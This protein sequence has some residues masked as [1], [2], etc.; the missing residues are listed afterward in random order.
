[1]FASAASQFAQLG[2]VTGLGDGIGWENVA[3]GVVMLEGGG[4]GYGRG[5]QR[6]QPCPTAEGPHSTF[7]TGPDGKI[8]GYA[9]W[10]ANPPESVRI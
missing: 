7:K 10:E 6:L 1:M 5:G 3:S 9:T 8:R 2:A 4:G